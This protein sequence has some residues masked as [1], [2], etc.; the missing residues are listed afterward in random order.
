M[1]GSIALKKSIIEGKISTNDSKSY[2]H[3][4]LFMAFIQDDLD[5]I[6]IN[7]KDE[8]LS[9]DIIATI[10]VLNTIG[11]DIKVVGK[12]IT[13]EKRENFHAD[14]VLDI[15]VLESGSTLRFVLPVIAKLGLSV[16]VFGQGRVL[17]RPLEDLINLLNIH[18]YVVEHNDGYLNC[19]GKLQPTV[20]KIKG[21]ISSQYITGLAFA[22]A[23]SKGG[24][25]EI[26]GTIVSKPYIELTL[27][28]MKKFGFDISINSHGLSIK[29]ARK[30]KKEDSTFDVEGD[31]SSAAALFTIGAFSKGIEVD[32]LSLKSAQADSAIIDILLRAKANI[33]KTN[34]GYKIANS[35]LK[36][37]INLDINSCPDLAPSLAVLFAFADGQT[38]LF[39]VRRLQDKESDRLEEIGIF[40]EKIG[41]KFILLDDEL[42][43]FGI[44][45]DIDVEL[46]YE[47]SDHRLAMAYTA[48]SQRNLQPTIISHPECIDKSFVN[49]YEHL[50]GIGLIIE[51][52]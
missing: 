18:G 52:K 29:K 1:K 5:K 41:R 11:A 3:R 39:G 16:R 10:G 13:V 25:I 8:D 42:R 6:T 15:N 31:W 2:L 27:Q 33:E 30:L 20:Y 26:E 49:F 43:I 38:T 46:T 51:N 23:L 47:G 21:Y 40:L 37:I 19:Y 7:L 9:N 35:N 4:L 44:D 28:V 17:S 34:M 45:E 50:S 36:P 48:I 32:N 12:T 24:Q 14:E 22:L